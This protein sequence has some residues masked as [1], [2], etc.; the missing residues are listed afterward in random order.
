M[1]SFTA[2]FLVFIS[3]TFISAQPNSKNEL[4]VTEFESATLVTE[5]QMDQA[6]VSITSK[7][8]VYLKN[9][10]KSMAQ[11]ID[12]T[13]NIKAINRVEES[14]KHTIVDGDVMI[15]IDL[16]KMTG[17]KMPNLANQFFG[18]MNNADISQLGSK[19]MGA[20]NA[21]RQEDGTMKIADLTCTRYI[22]TS[23]MMG[24]ETKTI[25]CK[26]KGYNLYEE[27]TGMG[28]KTLKKVISFKE[29]DPGPDSA[30]KPEPGVKIDEIR[31]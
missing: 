9:Y 6:G 30:W 27:S 11:Y 17:K 25:E 29:G 2:L 31:W 16:D 13:R 21:E 4:Q 26:Y 14:R 24:I 10:G 8:T 7:K 22:I 15:S 1:K 19:M 23:N 5:E 12:E 3:V 28:V 18:D 20:M